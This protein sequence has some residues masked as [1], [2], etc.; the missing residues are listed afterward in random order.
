MAEYHIH[1]KCI[2]EGWK[3]KN[4]EPRVLPIYQSTT[5]AYDSS[6]EMA[7]LFDLES[8]GFFYSRLANPTVDAVEQKIA[9]LEGGVGAILT[10]SGQ[11][12]SFMS[13]LNICQCGDH[14]VCASAIYGGT[15]NLFNKTMREMGINFTFVSPDASLEEINAAF[16]EK[17]KCVFAETLSNPALIV[18]DIEKF[19]QAAHSHNV[20]LI[21]DNTFPTPINCRPIE[22][23]ADIVIHSTTK[24]LDGHAVALGGVIVDGGKFNW[25]NDKFPALNT[26]D[27]TYHGVTYTKDFGNAAYLAKCRAHLMRDLGAMMSPNTAFLLNLGI[28]TLFLRVKQH[29]EN[30]LT[31]ANYLENHDKIT[32]VNYPGLKG[33]KYYDLAQK[34][35]P[36]GTC[37]VVS[38]GIKGGREAA[39]KFMDALKLARIA[40]HVAD[41]R[42]C[43]LHPASTTHRQLN[44]QELEAAGVKPDLIRLSVGLEDARDI[45]A[46]LE[47]ALAQI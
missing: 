2:Q 26:P 20:P 11:S 17:T 7:K 42:T 15:F 44:D 27:E 3:P 5:F 40:T 6:E 46:D 19:A 28:E 23:G 29:C 18:L 30:G 9:A 12:A 38:F 34:Y 8:S 32:W 13:V 39:T 47:Q 4:G 37:G 41:I 14:V 10:A 43:V 24:Y 45:I 22:H 16:T 35:L 33:N 21:V 36:N 31:I 25:E 1:T